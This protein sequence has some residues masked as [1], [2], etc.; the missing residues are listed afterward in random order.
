MK[1]I[2]LVIIISMLVIVSVFPIVTTSIASEA[3]TIYVDDDGGA[4]YT[5]IQD[6][7]DA[8]DDGDTIYVYSGTYYENLQI[9]KSVTLTSEDKH[10]TIIDGNSI[11]NVVGVTV[12]S[13]NFNSFTVRNGD[14]YYAGIHVYD[15]YDT[16][17]SDCIVS[18]NNG[19]GIEL[20][21]TENVLVSNCIISS[22]EQFGIVIYG[23]RQQSSNNIVSNCIISNNDEGIF[24]D[25][26][27]S[28]SIIK[29]SI[30][31]NRINGIYLAFAYDSEI[32][33][34]NFIDNN[35]NAYFWGIFHNSWSNNYWD[36]S[37]KIGIKIILGHAFLFPWLNFDW[38]PAD[39]PHNIE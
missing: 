5:R 15:S 28:N 2:K 35:R 16:R 33:E 27:T 30:T 21:L 14:I 31:D 7:I 32:N 26:T 23:D 10:N 20:E 39:E 4:D 8:A 18:S 38:N 1:S 9:D 3:R 25:D 13:V 19:I 22:N 36:K 12:D 6:A 37:I 17:I 34:N 24:L 11:G 29:N